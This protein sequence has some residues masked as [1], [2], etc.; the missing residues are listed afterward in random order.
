MPYPVFT[1]DFSAVVYRG[2]GLF[3]IKSDNEIK[4]QAAYIF[5][6]WPT[7]HDNN[8]DFVTQ[9]GYLPVTDN[10]IDSLFSNISIVKNENYRSVYEA[11]DKMNREY[12]FYPLP[13]Y[14]GASDTQNDFENNV[15][16]VLRTAHI[17][18]TRRVSDGEDPELVLNELVE[19]SLAELRNLSE[20]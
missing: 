18:Y 2:G 6:Q 13:L 4:N 1:D 15:K 17:Q 20:K 12:S 16:A 7:E 19:S 14:N 11:V 10:A 5:A 8:L 9:A 3:A